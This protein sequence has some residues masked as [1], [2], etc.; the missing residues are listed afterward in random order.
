MS[1]IPIYRNELVNRDTIDVGQISAGSRQVAQESQALA[2][3]HSQIA[4]RNIKVSLENSMLEYKN[5]ANEQLRQSFDLYSTDPQKLQADLKNRMREVSKAVPIALRPQ[6][7]AWFN[8]SAGAYIAKAGENKIRLENDSLKANSLTAIKNATNDARVA[9]SG[10][11][12]GDPLKVEQSINSLTSATTDMLQSLRSTNSR[13]DPIYSQVEQVKALENFR[14][15]TYISSI[16]QAFDEATPEARVKLLEDY[17]SG[18]LKIPF[19][20]PN[21]EQIEISPL[22]Q[23]T[24]GEY[25]ATRKYMVTALGDMA[26]KEKKA[27]TQAKMQNI[28]SGVELPD[29]SD[30]DLQKELNEQYI[31]NRESLTEIPA[32]Q[33]ASILLN[34]VNTFNSIPEQ[35]KNDV[36]AWGKSGDIEQ[37]K[38]SA[39]FINRLEGSNRY[40]LNQFNNNDIA[41]AQFLSDGIDSG[42]DFQE[43]LKQADTIFNSKDTPIYQQRLRDFDKITAGEDM[44]KYAASAINGK[45]VGGFIGNLFGSSI[46]DLGINSQ[47]AAVD[48]KTIYQAQYAL[49]G[50][51]KKSRE[52]SDK[53]INSMYSESISMTPNGS[54]MI[55]RYPPEMFYSVE[56]QSNKWI[57]Q[58]GIDLV[59]KLKEEQ[60]LDIDP[61]KVFLVSDAIT[62]QEAQEGKYPSYS[63]VVQNE[64]GAL[65]SPFESTNKT[66]LRYVPDM[67]SF[68]NDVNRKKEEK[69]STD[70]M[71]EINRER[72]NNKRLIFNRMVPKPQPTQKTIDESAAVVEQIKRWIRNGRYFNSEEELMQQLGEM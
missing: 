18:N 36:I 29:P 11:L 49:S 42:V 13:G 32:E 40:L 4:A 72:E 61:Q 1:N 60:G 10:L 57:R 21:G 38:T 67:Q 19:L 56:G 17:S 8:D 24:R 48:Y 31:V 69:I 22:E 16:R 2:D 52:Y 35:M 70:R 30:K 41:R 33:R 58:Q 46:N 66:N 63:L 51:E 55:G 34:T 53:I 7:D 68:I 54:E 45:F 43:R 28:A 37:V 5:L 3:L 9:T 47:R 64:Y 23:L 39:L 71:A 12:S 65:I 59:Q 20:G 27:M 50:D 26:A 62:Q 25:E 44:A 6:A 15:E 14:S